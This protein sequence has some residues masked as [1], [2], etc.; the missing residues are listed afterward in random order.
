MKL[1]NLVGRRF[2]R[3]IVIRRHRDGER[4]TKWLCRCDCGKKKIVASDKLLNGE[5]KSC[6]CL[7]SEMLGKR[8]LKHGNTI[9]RKPTREYEAWANAKTRCYN[10]RNEKYKNYGKRG[11]K[12]CSRWKDSFANFIKDMGKC[13][14][15]KTLDRK[16][17]NGDY[18]PLNCQWSTRE[19][20]MNNTTKN[21]FLKFKGQRLTIA[22]WARMFGYNYKT[23]YSLLRYQNKTMEE[24]SFGR[25]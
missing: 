20:Q 1:V 6:R 16:N 2:G 17:V 14:E 4:H 15:G 5:T 11:I 19:E 8:S 24:L 10:P 7:F 9:N 13:P 21:I 3:L 25:M 12:M 18:E 22:Q 23:F